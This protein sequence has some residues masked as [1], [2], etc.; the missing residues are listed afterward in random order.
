MRIRN[1][2]T[3][4]HQLMDEESTGGML[5]QELLVLAH[6]QGFMQRNAYSTENHELIDKESPMDADSDQQAQNALK[7]L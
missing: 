5:W 3:G 6:A 2:A 7:F 4:N 1:T